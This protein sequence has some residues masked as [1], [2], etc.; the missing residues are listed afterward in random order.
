M[1]LIRHWVISQAAGDGTEGNAYRSPVGDDYPH[2]LGPQ[3]LVLSNQKRSFGRDE[4]GNPLWIE[5]DVYRY[6]V[7]TEGIR[8]WADVLGI[9]YPFD[10]P[11]HIAECV[12]ELSVAIDIHGDS[13]Y[14]ILAAEVADPE[15][16][17]P[18][19]IEGWGRNDPF[20]QARWTPI[21]DGLV[22]VGVPD[23]VVDNWWTNN[24]GATPLEFKNAL[25]AWARAQQE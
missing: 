17:T 7:T 22:T 4:D 16:E 1:V 20:T 10:P 19:Q 18:S 2:E 5:G 13:K 21:R 6:G 9:S 12:S 24:P 3:E 14:R 23:T 25:V 8:S 15:D 11:L